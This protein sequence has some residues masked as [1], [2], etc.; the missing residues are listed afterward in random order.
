MSMAMHTLPQSCASD[1]AQLRCS[2]YEI[3]L[4]HWA[5]QSK[6]RFQD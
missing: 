2:G 6:K 3:T 5:Q 1:Y 4:T